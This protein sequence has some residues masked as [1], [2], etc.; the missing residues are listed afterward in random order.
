[1][2]Q[3]PPCGRSSDIRSAMIKQMDSGEEAKSVTLTV[4]SSLIKSW[5]KAD[6][7]HLY[8][9]FFMKTE[10]FKPTLK[11]KEGV[12]LPNWEVFPTKGSLMAF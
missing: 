10:G 12:C 2:I 4:Y 9:K 11:H 1:M 3:D 6:L 7:S 8:K 5:P